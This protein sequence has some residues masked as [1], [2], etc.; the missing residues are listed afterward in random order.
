MKRTSLIP[1]KPIGEDRN[2]DVFN[3]KKAVYL[4]L[5]EDTRSVLYPNRSEIYPLPSKEI[6]GKVGEDSRSFTK[7]KDHVSP[8]IGSV[9]SRD[10]SI[11]K[12]LLKIGTG[13]YVDT[14]SVK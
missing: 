10:Y 11:R 2:Y 14:Y 8:K 3:K 9:D 13:G 4:T 1:R 7:P 12:P 6:T 5:Q